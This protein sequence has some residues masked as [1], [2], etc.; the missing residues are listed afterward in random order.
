MAA[1]PRV[2]IDAELAAGQE[3]ALPPGAARHVQVLRMQPG[4]TLRLFDGRAHPGLPQGADWT[5]EILAMGRSSVRVR[6]GLPEA[7][8][9]ELPRAVTLAVGMPANE[10]MDWLVE[11]ATELGA[12]AIEPLVCARS[13][14]R[15]DGER[16]LKKQAHWQA[17]AV[18]AA[19]QCGRARVPGIAAPRPLLARLREARPPATACALLS[20]A[21][22]AR[23]LGPWLAALPPG[24]ALQLLSGPEGGLSPEEEA[25]ACAAGWQPI[26][27]GPRTLR[28]ET[29]PLAV[30][31]AVDALAAAG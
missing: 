2:H 31:A 10:R 18:A 19:E 27:L 14:L 17:V 5:A 4:Q 28:A 13:V 15:L 8:E 7:V 30:L 26:S 23:A 20:L 29:A 3:L 9:R 21:P 24:Q 16:A 12:A 1:T 6:V 11:K 22:Q 25:E